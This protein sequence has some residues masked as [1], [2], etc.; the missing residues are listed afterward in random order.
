MEFIKKYKYILFNFKF[1]RIIY[2]KFNNNKFQNLEHLVL[3]TNSIVL[4][5]GSNFGEISH[6]LYDKY[7][8]NIDCYEP[9]KYAFYVLNNFFKKNQKIK[10][11]NIAV[12]NNDGIAKLY[13]H[14]L[15][16]NDPLRYSTASSLLKKR[17]RTF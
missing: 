12:S 7:K 11:F 1:L 5:F 9:N 4:D 6:Y 16:L 17:Q 3:N 15:N 2:Y 8:C 10:C 14:K 13:H